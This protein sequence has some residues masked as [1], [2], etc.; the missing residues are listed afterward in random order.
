MIVTNRGG[1]MNV[2]IFNFM[3]VGQHAYKQNCRREGDL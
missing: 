1:S 2:T 3:H